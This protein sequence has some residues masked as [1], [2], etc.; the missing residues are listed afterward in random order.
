MASLLLLLAVIGF[1][2]GPATGDEPTESAATDGEEQY[3]Q[4]AEHM[5]RFGMRRADDGTPIKLIDRP[6]LSFGDS[7]RAYNRG[8]LW[9]WGKAGRPAA[10]MELF[11]AGDEADEWH[12]AVTLCSSERV[13]LKASKADIWTPSQAPPEM[14]QIPDAPAPSETPARRLRQ[15]KELARRFTAHEIWGSRIELRLLVQPVHRYDDRPSK[16]VDGAVFVVAHDTNPEA[17]LLLDALGASPA[18]ARWHYSLM[19]S[20][21]AEI[22][23]EF[24]EKEVWT[25]P[26]ARVDAIGPTAA[27]SSFRLPVEAATKSK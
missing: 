12:H 23:V 10:F 16:I 8:T 2:Q 22:H 14:K 3:R 21:H 26:L 25:C 1:C 9:G 20:G 11:R 18:E 5:R 6:L 4:A 24:D 15:M 27:Y 7:A 17:V 13:I 19:R